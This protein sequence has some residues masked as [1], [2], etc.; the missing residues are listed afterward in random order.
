MELLTSYVLR[1]AAPFVA[2]ALLIALTPREARALR[3]AGFILLFAV[4]RD[5]MTPVGL[6]TLSPSLSIRFHEAPALLWSLALASQ[7]MVVWSHLALGGLRDLRVWFAARQP[8]VVIAGVVGA[9]LV[10]APAV[11]ASRWTGALT[12]RPVDT[13][14]IAGVL[15]LTLCGNVLEEVLFRGHLHAQLHACGLSSSRIVLLSAGTFMA[16]HAHLAA[17]TTTIGWPVLVFT[18]YEGAICA[19]LR[20]RT[21]LAAACLAH[22]LGLFLIA[23]T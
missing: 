22:G 15:A 12:P 11:L 17:V 1:L 8:V 20:E 19:W 4:I 7:G 9:L 6:W 13:S 16:C 10:A 2:L 5:A 3:L 23:I 21:G 14:V 18:L